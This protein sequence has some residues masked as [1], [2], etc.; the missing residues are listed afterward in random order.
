MA[1]ILG[2]EMEARLLRSAGALVRIVAW[3]RRSA[4]SV[5]AGYLDGAELVRIAAKA[6]SH[7]GKQTFA[8]M[9]RYA[10][11]VWRRRAQLVGDADVIYVHDLFLLPLAFVLSIAKRKLLVYDAHE[12]YALMEARRYPKRGLV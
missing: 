9:T 3:D 5:P 2:W 11:Q 8:A 1:R 12:N 10:R 4:T 6:P 7:G